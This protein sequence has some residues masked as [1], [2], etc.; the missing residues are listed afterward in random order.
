MN[1]EAYKRIDRYQSMVDIAYT[2]LKIHGEPMDYKEISRIMTDEVGYKTKGKTPWAT[3]NSEI[4]RDKRFIKHRGMVE[5]KEWNY[6]EDET[7][8]DEEL[9]SSTI[10]YDNIKDQVDDVTQI[11]KELQCPNCKKEI[12]KD[13]NF[14]PYCRFDLEY[15][16]RNCEKKMEL[17]WSFCPYCGCKKEVQ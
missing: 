16:C 7:M 11:H 4:G 13:Y 5:L 2:I 14:C 8:R 1:K 12:S 6:S 10:S 17:N 9:R 3:L 15:H